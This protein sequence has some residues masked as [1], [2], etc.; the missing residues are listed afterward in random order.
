MNGTLDLH[1]SLW[2]RDG[3]KLE[4]RGDR[5]AVIGYDERKLFGKATNRMVSMARV[6]LTID[7]EG[8][9]DSKLLSPVTTPGLYHL[10]YQRTKRRVQKNLS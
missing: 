1:I 6:Q 4:A 10:R 9:V 7:S 5:D 3:W 8:R 2:A